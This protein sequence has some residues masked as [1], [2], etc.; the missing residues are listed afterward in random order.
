MFPYPSWA[1]FLSAPEWAEIRIATQYRRRTAAAPSAGTVEV[2]RFRADA[3]WHVSVGERDLEDFLYRVE[4]DG[5]IFVDAPALYSNNPPTD[6]SAALV[7]RRTPGPDAQ[8]LGEPCPEAPERLRL[9]KDLLNI[10]SD[11]QGMVSWWEHP[12]AQLLCRTDL[13]ATSHSVITDSTLSE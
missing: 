7:L 13:P 8:P 9:R 10:D 11:E 1:S 2:I 4:P 5:F 3:A 6:V 12:P